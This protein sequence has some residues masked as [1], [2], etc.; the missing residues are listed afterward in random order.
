MARKKKKGGERL[1]DLI[2]EIGEPATLELLAEEAIE[3]AH[4]ALK[5]AR[6]ERGENPTPKNK[7]I[8]MAELMEELGDYNIVSGH[9]MR[10][11]WYNLDII[12]NWTINKEKRM[13]TRIMEAKGK[14]V[15]RADKCKK[16]CMDKFQE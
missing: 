11:E 12:F 16:E 9:L 15:K 14:N 1:N 2:K 8:A 4:A 3:V 6:I 10:A 5:L 13:E 7:E